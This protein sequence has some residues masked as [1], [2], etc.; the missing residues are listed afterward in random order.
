MPRRVLRLWVVG[1]VLMASSSRTTPAKEALPDL[2][3]L[4][5]GR[6][7]LLTPGST[8]FLLDFDPPGYS[9]CVAV[10]KYFDDETAA[11]LS[12]ELD[13]MARQQFLGYLAEGSDEIRDRVTVR[14]FRKHTSWWNGPALH[15]IY[16]V[17]LSGIEPTFSE[18]KD[19]PKETPHEQPAGPTAAELLLEGRDLRK[20]GR[21]EDARRAFQKLRSNHPA[22]PEARR[23]LREIYFTNAAESGRHVRRNGLQP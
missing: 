11:D 4:Q 23:A 19:L 10:E 20:A 9:V 21:W 17:P 16:F 5:A 14:G 15:A 12:D 2:K 22:S 18:A 8:Q 3:A 6:P 13:L 7:E 1:F